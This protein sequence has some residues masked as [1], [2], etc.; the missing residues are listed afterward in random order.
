MF[1]F[2]NALAGMVLATVASASQF[3]G[4]GRPAT[5]AE[6]KAWDIDVRP[7]F[8]GLPSGSGSVQKGQT[9]GTTS[10]RRARNIR[11]IER[12]VSRLVGGYT[13]A[14]VKAAG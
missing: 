12:G 13:T 5:P 7:D 11:R 6:I 2:I 1:R 4:V 10:A 14:D 3:P 9:S 8:K